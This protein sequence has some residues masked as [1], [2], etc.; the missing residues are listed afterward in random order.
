MW[1]GGQWG[2][3]VHTWHRGEPNHGLAEILTNGEGDGGCP[4]GGSFRLWRKH[5]AP[6]EQ[7]PF[8]YTWKLVPF[9]SFFS[10][11]FFVWLAPLCVCTAEIAEETSPRG[12][13]DTGFNCFI[14]NW[15]VSS[16]PFP[17]SCSFCGLLGF[18]IVQ[19]AVK[20]QQRGTPFL[21]FPV[22]SLENLQHVQIV[23]RNVP[24]NLETTSFWVT[25]ILISN[26]SFR[27]RSWS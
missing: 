7:A 21:P 8:T 10:L 25:M 26:D 17:F 1:E 5:F 15:T 22:R 19:P 27:D 20:P 9:L 3:L 2:Y 4:W 16:L 12:C 14:I 13:P 6:V 23:T 18:S 24:A 11:F